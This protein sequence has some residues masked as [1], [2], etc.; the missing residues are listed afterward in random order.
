MGHSI[1]WEQTVESYNKHPIWRFRTEFSLMQLWNVEG[2]K[3]AF[4]GILSSLEDI[5]TDGSAIPHSSG[6]ALRMVTSLDSV[7]VI[8]PQEDDI[9]RDGNTFFLLSLI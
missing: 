2:V 3:K 7:S 1:I 9:K 8:F 6:S 5:C 4:Q